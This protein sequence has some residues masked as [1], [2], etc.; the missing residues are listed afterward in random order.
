MKKTFSERDLEILLGF[1]HGATEYIFPRLRLVSITLDE[2]PQTV[3]YVDGE[4]S[5]DDQ[6]SLSLIETYAWTDFIEG[7]AEGSSDIIRVDYPNPIPD[8][9]G[10][11]VYARKEPRPEGPTEFPVLDDASMKKDDKIL[12]A[13]QRAVI[14]RIFPQIRDIIVSCKSEIAQI[15]VR[16]DGEI[17]QED[18]ATLEKLRK[19]FLEQLPRKEVIDC[20]LSVK[21]LDFPKRER[22]M[23]GRL[24]YYRKEY[25]SYAPLHPYDVYGSMTL[26]IQKGIHPTLAERFLNHKGGVAFVRSFQ[27]MAYGQIFP[28]L[29]LVSMRHKDFCF[30]LFFYVDGEL[31]ESDKNCVVEIRRTFGEDLYHRVVKSTSAEIIRIDAPAP[32]PHYP[33]ICLFARKEN[34]QL[35]STKHAAPE[36]D[37]DFYYKA[38]LAMQW[39]MINHIFPRIRAIQLAIE[40]HSVLMR[41]VVY[42]ALSDEEKSTI[43]DMKACFIGQMPDLQHCSLELMQKSS[44]SDPDPVYNFPETVYFSTNK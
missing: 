20:I 16:V 22:E 18:R 24:V 25:E 34:P 39:A 3:F 30:E 9:L 5:E 11:C 38:L 8:F 41:V 13:M 6:E 42:E 36:S 17:A 4:L 28:Q 44:S 7:M 33:G 2:H 40:N 14:N 15:L 12:I 32:I 35:V 31:S 1:Q 26:G 10:E 27:K 43:E 29:R 37:I 23:E 19:S 21:R